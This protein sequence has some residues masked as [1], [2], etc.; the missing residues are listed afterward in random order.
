MKI[1]AETKVRRGTGKSPTPKTETNGSRDPR[2][3]TTNNKQWPANWTPKTESK[4]K[5]K[6][7]R[8]CKE[9]SE[10]RGRVSGPKGVLSPCENDQLLGVTCDSKLIS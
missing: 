3:I 7:L 6:C 9:L 1:H 8:Q 10:T 5:R 2:K 4:N